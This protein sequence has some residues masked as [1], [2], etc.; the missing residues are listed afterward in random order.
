MNGKKGFRFESMHTQTL[1][2]SLESLHKRGTY[3]SKF[4]IAS[5]NK[6][7]TRRNRKKKKK[8]WLNTLAH[9]HA[10]LVVNFFSY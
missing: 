9:I 5:P 4:G 3:Y 7:P 10:T 6:P 1:T 8:K 2:H